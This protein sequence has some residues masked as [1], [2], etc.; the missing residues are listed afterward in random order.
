M[1]AAAAPSCAP[2]TRSRVGRVELFT[3]RFKLKVDVLSGP[4]TD[5]A[6]GKSSSGQ[7]GVKAIDAR[8]ERSLGQ[9]IENAVFSGV[10]A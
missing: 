8:I 1:G 2:T 5:N 9:F 10:P 4:A 6:V 7:V 3:N